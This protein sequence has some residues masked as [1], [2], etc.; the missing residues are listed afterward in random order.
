MANNFVKNLKSPF[1]S[2]W[3]AIASKGHA[4][5]A[6]AIRFSA[7]RGVFANPYDGITF[8][9]ACRLGY[10]GL[11][12]VYRCINTYADAVGSVRWVAYTI[13]KDG[14]E[15]LLPN[16]PLEVLC[17]K[18]NPFVSRKE[19]YSVWAIYLMLAGETF[20]EVAY[21]K[22]RPK[23]LYTLR[24]DWVT[25]VP[26]TIL[27]TDG[28]DFKADNL[29]ATDRL[30]NEEVMWFKFPNPDNDYEGLSPLAAGLR[31]IETENRIINWNNSL[32]ENNAIPGG[33]LSIPS[34][35]LDD[36]ER[37]EI[38]QSLEDEY[39]GRG[40]NRPMVLYG[41][42]QWQ[43]MSLGQKDLDFEGLKKL[44]RQEIH[45][46]LG[47]PE[48]LTAANAEAKYENK[49]QARTMFWEDRVMPLLDWLADLINMRLAPLYGDGVLVRADTTTQPAMIDSFIRKINA[50]KIL[51]DCGWELNRVNRRLSLSMGDVP[52]GDVA[53]MAT[54]K[55]PVSSNESMLDPT[56]ALPGDGE[57]EDPSTD[58]K[59]GE[60]PNNEEDALQQG[61]AGQGDGK[62][63]P[64]TVSSGKGKANA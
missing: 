20:W 13:D 28:Y 56:T 8:A 51:V 38:L 22:G 9:E 25:P 26:H 30:K 32:L 4:I 43:Q 41:G 34:T 10:K 19:F 21:E 14:T 54:T 36:E 55:M 39:S 29:G 33:I 12:W 15:R 35:S 6:A 52:W 61:D 16:H 50:A 2:A 62:K 31:S 47:V 58:P 48:E 60:D 23:Y 11:V 24:P 45:G 49:A 40:V 63:P 44:N 53:W 18:P 42:M 27:Y 59:P 1:I 3:K 7:F 5:R 17:N 46:C 64:K 37:K 57:D